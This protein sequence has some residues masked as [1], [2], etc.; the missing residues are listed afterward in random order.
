[1]LVWCGSVHDRKDE[2]ASTFLH[3]LR[4]DCTSSS[5]GRYALPSCT[6]PFLHPRKHHYLR[7][8]MFIPIIIC[9]RLSPSLSPPLSITLRFPDLNESRIQSYC[10][11]QSTY[12][13]RFLPHRRLLSLAFSTYLTLPKVTSIR[14]LLA[15]FKQQPPI[16]SHKTTSR[17]F[18]DAN[19]LAS[20]PSHRLCGLWDRLMGLIG[21][22]MGETRGFCVDDEERKRECVR[23]RERERERKG[24]LASAELPEITYAYVKCCI[25]DSLI[26]LTIV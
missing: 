8:H 18:S 13:I 19:P 5:D 16:P 7:N 20:K 3:S 23:E 15:T 9:R 10:V 6:L 1:M 4:G 17:A 26:L 2:F 24:C 11:F 21:M 14:R 22:L 25:D 12:P